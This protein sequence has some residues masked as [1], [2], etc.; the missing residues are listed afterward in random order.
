MSY[1][2]SNIAYKEKLRLG[3]FFLLTPL[4]S[5]ITSFNRF[6]KSKFYSN[7][8]WIFFTF[9]G[10]VFIYSDSSADSYRYA[11][12]FQEFSNLDSYGKR[13][14]FGSG[15][16]LDYYRYFSFYFVSLFTSQPRIY[17]IFIALIYGFFYKSL[18]YNFFIRIKFDLA[19]SDVIA[20]LSFLFI[21]PFTGFIFVRFSTALLVF[22]F[23]LIKYFETKQIKY[24]L[25]LILT[26]FIHFSF[27]LP[28]LAVFSYFLIPKG[29]Y[30]LFLYLFSLLFSYFDFDTIR[31]FIENYIPK[32]IYDVKK[33]YLNDEYKESISVASEATNWYIQY[34]VDILKFS[35]ALIIIIIYF[36]KGLKKLTNFELLNFSLYFG[37]IAN[38]ISIVPTGARF[39]GISIT[40]IWYIIILNYINKGFPKFQ[41]S[42]IYSQILVPVYIFIIIVGFRYLFDIM[43]I[44]FFISNFILIFIEVSETPIINFIKGA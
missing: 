21:L 34:R 24:I 39:L 27:I 30:L 32:E 5:I 31:T 20:I 29:R 36:R 26:Y 4:L 7:L 44:D 23:S 13:G 3:L 1:Q 16:N 35:S 28:I 15:L 40:L 8:I 18:L 11:E 38:I 10:S 43:P 6:H 41:I 33:G 17:F 9:L 42:N 19:Y 22:I 12:W 37:I 2:N 14:Y 25:L